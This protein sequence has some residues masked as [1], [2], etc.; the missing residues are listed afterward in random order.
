M[1]AL[2][3]S[4]QQVVKVKY[5]APTDEFKVPVGIDLTNVPNDTV[6]YFFVRANELVIEMNDG[7]EHVVQSEYNTVDTFEWEYDED[8]VRVVEEE[9]D[10]PTGCKDCGNVKEN[11]EDLLCHSCY[12][13]SCVE[14][15]EECWCK[16]N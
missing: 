1:S 14:T 16:K 9:E 8:N 15:G 5:N 11:D 13:K 10:V 4:K 6:N 12:H 2:I 7:T 3:S